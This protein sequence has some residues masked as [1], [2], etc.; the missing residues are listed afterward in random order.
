VEKTKSSSLVTRGTPVRTG[1]GSRKETRDTEGHPRKKKRTSLPE[2]EKGP[3]WSQ[4]S[5][6]YQGPH[7]LW[8]RK[9]KTVRAKGKDSKRVFHRKETRKNNSRADQKETRYEWEPSISP[10]PSKGKGKQ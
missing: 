1:P 9:E 6:N 2:N 10:W 4:T 5:D 7:Q 3:L 8:S